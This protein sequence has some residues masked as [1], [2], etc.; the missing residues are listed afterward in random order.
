MRTV[1]YAFWGI[2]ILGLLWT[3]TNTWFDPV[4]P[5]QVM[6]SLFGIAVLLGLGAILEEIRP[7]KRKE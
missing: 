1:F 4:Q 2:A 7:L 5:S 6:M 3:I